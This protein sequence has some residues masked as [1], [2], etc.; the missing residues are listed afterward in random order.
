[1]EEVAES[2]LIVHVVD[3]SNENAITQIETVN[4]VLKE[5]GAEHKE[6]IIAINKID[7]AQQENIHAIKAKYDNCIEISALNATNLDGLLKEIEAKLFANIIEAKLIIPYK[8]SKVVSNLHEL[9]C[10]KYEEYKEDGIEI[11]IETTEDII[12]RYREYLV[13]NL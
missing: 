10:V 9:K 6:N 8:D 12:N 3:G 1:M 5:I 13:L 7:V 4:R 11:I 2:D